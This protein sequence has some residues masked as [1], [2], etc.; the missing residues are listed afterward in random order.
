[1]KHFQF[2][3]KWVV[4]VSLRGTYVRVVV[5]LLRRSSVNYLDLTTSL[6][7]LFL[8]LQCLEFLLYAI[9]WTFNSN[10]GKSQY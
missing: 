4:I 2:R 1:M 7:S 10:C 5:L 6:V 3:V 8:T 9:F